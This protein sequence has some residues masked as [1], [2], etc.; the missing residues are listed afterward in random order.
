MDTKKFTT[1]TLKQVMVPI[2]VYIIFYISTNVIYAYNISQDVAK[3]PEKVKCQQK[4]IDSIFI[5]V[6]DL[7]NRIDKQDVLLVRAVGDIKETNENVKN[8]YNILL[9]SKIK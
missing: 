8:I 3:L 1:E 6:G 2:I 9:T 7:K 4:Q 5:S